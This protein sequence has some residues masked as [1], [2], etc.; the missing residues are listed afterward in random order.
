MS[1]NAFKLRAKCPPGTVPVNTAA[2]VIS[3]TATIGQTLAV[4]AGTWSN[5]PTGYAYQWKR[6]GSNISGATSS[7]YVLVTADGGTTVSCVVTATN[8]SGSASASATGVSVSAP[9]YDDGSS[10]AKS[11][12]AQ[13]PHALDLSSGT[14]E[15]GVSMTMRPSWNVAGVDYRV[16]P[17]STQVY[18]ALG[19]D[20]LPSNVSYNSTTKFVYVDPAASTV[21][22]GWDLTGYTI[23]GSQGS[24][25]LTITNNKWVQ[26]NTAQMAFYVDN[27][28]NSGL[29]E[30]AF[31]DLDCN[32]VNTGSGSIVHRKNGGPSRTYVHHNYVKNAGSDFVNN[33]HDFDDTRIV[34]NVL[35]DFCW[36]AA[37]HSD[38]WQE[39]TFDAIRTMSGV[40]FR[41]NLIIQSAA[42]PVSHLPGFFNSI[43]SHGD[44]AAGCVLND[45]Y[46]DHNTII[47]IGI[48]GHD[49]PAGYVGVCAFGCILQGFGFT[50]EGK[51]NGLYV[52][53]NYVYTDY[54]P[55]DTPNQQGFYSQPWKIQ[56]TATANI[57]NV[58]ITTNYQM[59]D[60]SSLET[61][62]F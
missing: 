62:S 40:V 12:A 39:I 53:N 10:V 52:N 38:G 30:V 54:N 59:R 19:V 1:G 41:G 55:S 51:T 48:T 7:T 8:A 45:T 24:G 35:K 3:G 47:G 56:K 43:L 6:D 17:S 31:N 61:I 36:L 4:S 13:H 29:V 42:D 2:P 9:S 21:L 23:L 57:S 49:S 5:S 28:V 20:A 25:T 14:N 58:A 16:G 60:G 37:N 18:K 32:K 27:A 46:M 34:Y 33:I 26:T 50:P 11:G 15:F 22:D 44:G